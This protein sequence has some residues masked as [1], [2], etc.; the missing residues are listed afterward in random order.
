MSNGN[1]PA[2]VI[3]PYCTVLY[4][5]TMTR[6]DEHSNLSGNSVK[7]DHAEQSGSEDLQRDTRTIPHDAQMVNVEPVNI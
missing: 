4:C 6:H 3:L 1:R 2:P 7:C 5:D